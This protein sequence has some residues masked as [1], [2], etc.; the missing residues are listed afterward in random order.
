MCNHLHSNSQPIPEKGIGYKMFRK[1]KYG[2]NP[3]TGDDNNFLFYHREWNIWGNNDVHKSIWCNSDTDIY[4]EKYRGFCFF[5]NI[6]EALKLYKLWTKEIPE[7]QDVIYEIRYEKGL[8]KHI[9][10]G[11]TPNDT[12]YEIALCKEFTLE[13]F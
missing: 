12:P 11:I 1:T 9:E 13:T 5:L 10:T 6:G 4:R 2:L 3:I 7:E 8:G